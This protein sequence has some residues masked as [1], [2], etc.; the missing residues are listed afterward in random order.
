MSTWKTLTESDAGYVEVLTTSQGA[1]FGYR[2]KGASAGPQ[3]VVAGVCPN[4]EQVFER[5]LLTPTLPWMRG[6]LIVIRLDALDDMLGDLHG[7]AP[8]GPI[9]RTIILPWSS[10]NQSNETEV[11]RNYHIVLRACADLGMISGRGVSRRSE[12][13]DVSNA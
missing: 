6:T 2:L 4:A 3:V 12:R 11:R 13:A 9:D 5:L 8:L 10:A 1:V 7:L